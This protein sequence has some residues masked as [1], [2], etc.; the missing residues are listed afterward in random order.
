MQAAG[1]G[2]EMNDYRSNVYI[3]LK[4]D[5]CPD[6]GGP[7][8]VSFSVPF[9][10]TLVAT[11]ECEACGSIYEYDACDSAEAEAAVYY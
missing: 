6:C 10:Y 3:Q 8:E 4:R 11:I 1:G 9:P 5:G 7:V 2:G